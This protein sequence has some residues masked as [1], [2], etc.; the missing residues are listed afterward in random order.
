M[1]PKNR[2]DRFALKLRMNTPK[3]ELWFQEF[4]KANGLEI[5]SDEYNVRW[6]RRIPDLVNHKYKYVI[7]IDGTIHK[8]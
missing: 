2:I 8:K 4:W 6:C 1:K 5:P 3:S 7:E